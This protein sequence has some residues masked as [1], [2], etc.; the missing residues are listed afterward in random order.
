MALL[1]LLTTNGNFLQQRR[2][3][4]AVLIP[5]LQQIFCIALIAQFCGSVVELHAVQWGISHSPLP[6]LTL[7]MAI[8]S[9]HLSWAGSGDSQGHSLCC[10]SMSDW[11]VE[12]IEVYQNCHKGKG[13]T[14]EVR[15]G[16]RSKKAGPAAGWEDSGLS[17]CVYQSVFLCSDRNK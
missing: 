10:V 17:K 2:I 14:Q 15:R 13:E 9:H 11:L 1:D 3:L 6:S 5:F 7:L 12:K 16:Q 4:P 8:H